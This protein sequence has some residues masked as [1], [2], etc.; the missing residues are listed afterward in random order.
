MRLRDCSLAI[1][2]GTHNMSPAAERAAALNAPLRSDT[3]CRPVEPDVSLTDGT[4]TPDALPGALPVVTATAARPAAQSVPV[5]ATP[6]GAL[7]SELLC[8]SS[9]ASSLDADVEPAVQASGEKYVLR[10]KPPG[11]VI[12]GAHAVDRECERPLLE[13][14]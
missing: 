9:V 4:P 1:K 6:R 13:C 3:A 5:R 10:K 7:P 8:V 14:Y 11:K 12:K 2:R